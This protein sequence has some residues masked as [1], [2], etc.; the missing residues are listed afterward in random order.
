VKAG[1]TDETAK[2][3]RKLHLYSVKNIDEAIEHT[4]EFSGYPRIF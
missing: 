3:G 4:P 2:S 1:L